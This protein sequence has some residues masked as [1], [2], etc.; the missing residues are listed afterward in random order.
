MKIKTKNTKTLL[1]LVLLAGGLASCSVEEQEIPAEEQYAREFYKNF[2]VFDKNQDWSVVEQK[3]ITVSCAAPTHVKVYEEQDGQYRLAADYK[4]VTNGQTITFDG[5]KG[6]DDNFLVSLDGMFISAKNGE[7]VNAVQE[8]ENTSRAKRTSG[9]GTLYNQFIEEVTARTISVE[10]TGLLNNLKDGEDN[11]GRAMFHIPDYFLTK[12]QSP[13][14]TFYPVYWNSEKKHTVGVYYHDPG[15]GRTKLIPIYTDHEGDEVKYYDSTAGEWVAA[16]NTKQSTDLG[17]GRTWDYSAGIESK[18]YKIKL[19]D[20][21]IYGIYVE[22]NGKKYFSQ[23][24][25]NDDGKAHFATVSYTGSDESGTKTSKS[26]ILFDDDN[27]NDFNDLVICTFD[28]LKPI[29]DQ[30]VGW[31]VACEDLGGTYDFDFNDLV[32]RVYH[33]SGYEYADI[34]PVA[35][36]G[37]LPA[38]LWRKTVSTDAQI[39]NEWHSHFGKTATDYSST[40]MINTFSITDSV[41]HTIRIGTG[42]TFSM[43][44]FS[45]NS[46]DNGGIYIK[47]Q[48][49]NGEIKSILGPNP[50]TDTPRTPQMLI[51]PLKWYWPTEL[52]NIKNVYTGTGSTPSFETWA[53]DVKSNKNWVDYH[54][55]KAQYISDMTPRDADNPYIPEGFPVSKAE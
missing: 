7:T 12:S 23:K 44:E 5:M 41:S 14:N 32:F 16:G 27:D 50:H 19:T 33:T 45:S 2:G 54:N 39:S 36:G 8:S 22:V 51:L 9:S 11:T 20:N 55:E 29:T 53:K 3:S 17:E 47:V 46:E 30:S 52:V 31:T 6:D 10:S 49:A 37:T 35:A 43:I 24:N 25:L 15:N 48:Q 13:Y 21:V 4:G 34:V 40:Q 26:Y 18:G 42:A 28:E 1:A 38:W